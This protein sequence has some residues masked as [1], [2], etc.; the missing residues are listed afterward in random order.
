MVLL[1]NSKYIYSV[2]HDETYLE[3]IFNNCL[4]YVYTGIT[5][6]IYNKLMES[7]S[8]DTYFHEVIENHYSYIETYNS[9]DE[10][11]PHCEEDIPPF[12]D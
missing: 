7:P 11:P 5:T 10:L 4:K 12:F 8:P 2:K 9:R 1:I 3:V 6:E